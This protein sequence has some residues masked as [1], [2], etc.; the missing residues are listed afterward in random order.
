[1]LNIIIPV[2]DN[3]TWL[4]MC[5][6]ALHSWTS[7]QYTVTI[8]DNESKEEETKKLLRD[9]AQFEAD[10]RLR[11]RPVG[12]QPSIL[13]IAIE[14]A[15]EIPL[16][17][18]HNNASFSSSINAAVQQIPPRAQDFLVLLNSD[19]LVQRG[20]DI[21]MLADL[22]DSRVGLV[23]A[24]TQKD[25]A[26]GWQGDPD[27]AILSRG[28]GVA[29]SASPGIDPPFLI[30]F[31]VMLR[32]TVW[33]QIGQLDGETCQGWGGGED[34]DYSWRLKD[35]GYRLA[36]SKASVIHGCNQTYIEQGLLNVASVEELPAKAK[37]EQA[38]LIRLIGKY[39]AQR[40]NN[41]IATR[42]IVLIG[43]ISRTPMAHWPFVQSLIQ[44]MRHMTAHGMHIELQLCTRTFVNV[45]REKIT[46]WALANKASTGQD[47]TH[48]IFVDDD[49]VF[50]PDAFMKLIR[51]DKDVVAPVVYMRQPPHGVAVFEWTEAEKHE[52]AAR[53]K[54]EDRPVCKPGS[55]PLA[56]TKKS[57]YSSIEGLE[58][59]GL[60]KV[61]AVGFGMVC[62]KVE[63]LRRLKRER[64]E[65]AEKKGDASLKALYPFAD[66][67]E[68]MSF[69]QI[70]NEHGA[71]VFCDTNTIIGHMTDP[72]IVD[73]AYKQ[74]YVR[75]HGPAGRTE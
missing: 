61:D 18:P 75:E 23:G 71:S 50:Q 41:N 24:R 65:L 45:A 53:E 7:T 43:L 9:F 33:E 26:A 17:V 49:Q 42:P 60:R 5:L 35:A 32:R 64:L 37:M 39:G 46:E 2:R 14:V 21:D 8:V 36:I 15:S 1:M 48:L 70:A 57:G 10:R 69:C 27:G 62:M 59:K 73:A 4:S 54:G 19:V 28:S 58:G 47:F 29:D 72:V 63:V 3:P 44:S 74:R 20:W 52:K 66:F 11:G 51:A 34:L 22:A 55:V 25:G 13:P 38:N 67:G 68:D 6:T 30:F 12:R 31:C 16:I 56:A 40:V